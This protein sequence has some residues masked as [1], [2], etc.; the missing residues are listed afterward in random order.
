[1]KFGGNFA[2]QITQL[3][4]TVILKNIVLLTELPK[5]NL[6]NSVSDVIPE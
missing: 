1:M 6:A 2:A 4:P 5:S 3:C